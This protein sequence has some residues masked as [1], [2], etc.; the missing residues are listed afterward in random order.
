MSTRFLVNKTVRRVITILGC[1]IFLISFI[2]PFYTIS[3]KTLA[4]GSSTYYWSYVS[5]YHYSIDF[6]FGSSQYWFSN[7]WFSPYLDVGLRIPWILV[8]MFTIQALTLLFGVASM[9]FNRRMLSFAPVLLSLSTIALMVY[10]DMIEE[11]YFGEYQL[12]YYLVY[13][14][15]AMFIFAFLLNEE[16]KK[17]QA[18]KPAKQNGNIIPSSVK[19][20]DEKL[21][22]TP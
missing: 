2:S 9:I 11:I 16:T 10:T 14:S 4:G 20:N 5:D 19:S 12:G 21:L 15:V 17:M 7:Y 18:T 3:M 6:H 8:S 22:G 13:P 1:L